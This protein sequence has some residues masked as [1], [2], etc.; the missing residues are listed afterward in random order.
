M[1]GLTDLDSRKNKNSPG[2]TAPPKIRVLLVDDS[3]IALTSLKRALSTAP[4]IEVVGTARNGR[5]AL[6]MMPALKPAVVCTDLYMPVMSGLELTREIMNKYP[7]PILAVSVSVAKGSDNVFRLIEAGAIDVFTKPGFGAG[8]S[9]S[10][11]IAQLISKIRILS[12]VRVFKKFTE[13]APLLKPPEPQKPI[14]PMDIQN[15]TVLDIVVIGASTGG[16]KALQEILPELPPSFKIPVICV[17]HIADGFLNGFVEWLSSECRMN[18]SIARQGERPMP[19][20]IY[21]PQEQTHLEFDRNGRFI[22]SSG[23]PFSGHRPSVTLTMNSAA[24][25]FGSRTAGVLLTGMGNDG[26]EGMKAIALAGGLTIAQDEA[27]S[28]IF[29]MPKEAIAIGAVKHI[30]PLSSIADTLIRFQKASGGGKE[31]T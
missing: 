15:S 22:L 14:L 18:V 3:L 9:S 25:Y 21:F 4:D 8:L 23:E 13:T 16:P 20:N 31:E 10:V 28:V 26:S 7:C 1:N 27:S 17:Q 30:L 6:S 24:K 5:E 11:E 19:G 12:G 29:G 2:T